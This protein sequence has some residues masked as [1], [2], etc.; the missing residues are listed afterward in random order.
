MENMDIVLKIM[1][2]MYAYRK[3]AKWNDVTM[4]N[5][6]HR[7]MFILQGILKMGNRVKMNEISTYFNVTPA[8]VSQVI[9]CFEKKGWVEKKRY[10]ED[11][12]SVYIVVSDQA[13]ETLKEK[14]QLMMNRFSSFIDELG[15]DD[16]QA[17][18][19]ILEKG[20]AFHQKEQMEQSGKEKNND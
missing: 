4:S 13:I 20:I 6:R 12:R 5:M 11:K 15:E 9:K 1:Q 10:P 16:A 19:R 7:E 2:L 3:D 17:L 8:A 14:Q 18:V